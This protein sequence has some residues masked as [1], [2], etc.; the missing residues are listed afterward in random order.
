MNSPKYPALIFVMSLVTII[1]LLAQKQTEVQ[2]DW[3]EDMPSYENRHYVRAHPIPEFMEFAEEAVPLSNPDIKERL[4]RE[5]LVNSYWQSNA[6]L[7]IKR[8]NKYGPL[9]DSI[10]KDE[11]IPLDF[12]YLAVIESGLQNATSPA[13]AKGFWQFM[14]GTGREFG[15]EI[16]N[17]VDERFNLVLATKAAAQYL[18]QAKKEFGNWTLAAAAY[19]AGRARIR[20]EL[21]RQD[22][23][24]YYNLWLN[25]ETS[26]YIF[27]ILAVKRLLE[28]PQ[29]YGFEF[30]SDHLYTYIPTRKYIVDTAVTDFVHFAQHFGINYK[31]LKIHNPWLMEGHLNNASHK[32][33]TIEIPEAGFYGLP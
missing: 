28:H 9:I 14:R 11:Q 25:E 22:V 16:N 21:A 24:G 19:N 4:D 6:F 20:S 31:I 10:L 32:K 29:E 7:L 5:I 15:L 18:K 30:N 12:K 23:N 1:I 33:Y 27:R 26:R 13:G 8:L 17:N 2:T 3:P